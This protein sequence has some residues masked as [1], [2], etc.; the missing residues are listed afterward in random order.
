MVDV[1]QKRLDEAANKNDK[2]HQD[3]GKPTP[4]LPKLYRDFR[5]MFDEMANDIDGV[6]VSTPDHTHFAAAMWAIKHG[7][8]VCVQKPLAN[9]AVWEVRE[10]PQQAAKEAKVVTQMGNQG[11]TMEGQRLA[12]ELDRAGPHRHPERNRS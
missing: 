9:T 4:P 10:L 6:I 12:K 5:K 3:A 11:R 2:S 8:H 1:D 7:K